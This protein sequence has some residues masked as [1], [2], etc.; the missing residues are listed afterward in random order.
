MEI[1]FIGF[2]LSA[3]FLEDKWLGGIN[4]MHR[5]PMLHSISTCQNKTVHD[6]TVRRDN[7]RE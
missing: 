3:S 1:N 6:I 7:G 5:S 4:L 2:F